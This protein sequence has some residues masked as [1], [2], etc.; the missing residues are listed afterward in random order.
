MKNAIKHA[1]DIAAAFLLAAAIGWTI[2]FGAENPAATQLSAESSPASSTISAGQKFILR[3]ETA[4]HTHYTKKGDAIKFQTAGDIYSGERIVI[5][6]KSTVK[7]IVARSKRAGRLAGRAEV[8]L[9]LEQ[10]E[11]AD[12]STFPLPATITRAG[13]DPVEAKNGQPRIK[14][15]SGSGGSAGTVA[16]SGAQGAIIGVLFGGP[17]GAAYG[18]AIGAGISLGGMLLKRGPDVDLPQDTLFEAKFDKPFSLPEDTVKRM[19]EIAAREA[20]KEAESAKREN[21]RASLEEEKYRNPR[22]RP[23]LR[24]NERSGDPE[25]TPPPPPATE[26]AQP[27]ASP[28]EKAEPAATSDSTT[29]T[30]GT[31]R[32]SASPAQRPVKAKTTGSTGSS[33][34]APVPTPTSNGNAAGKETA[35]T[36]TDAF[37]IKV[38]V[39]MVMVDT[40]VRNKAGRMI[41]NLKLEDFRVFEDGQ[42]QTLGSY[43]RDEMPLA[44]ALVVDRSGSVTPYIY[45]LRRIA[46]RMLDQL[47][48]QDQVCLFSFADQVDRVVD[49][50]SDHDRIVNGLGRI[51]SGGG[52]NIVDAVY[53]AVNYL[54]QAAPDHRRA[55]ILISDNEATVASSAGEGETIRKALNTETVVYSIKTKGEKAPLSVNIPDLLGGSGPVPKM[56]RDTGGEILDASRVS[57]L[58][59]A[60]RTVLTRLRLRYSIGYYSSSTEKGAAFHTI[61]VRLVDRFGKPGSDYIIHARRGYYSI[62]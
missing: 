42:E 7:G 52:T 18:G 1:T 40:V 41:E 43:S 12:G 61:E 21:D 53:G 9:K 44:V 56:T 11:L 22:T 13:L 23:V 33:T 55:V 29:S 16:K 8:E 32:P 20:A 51:H 25:D 58:D 2:L 60:M 14:G 24:R 26:T 62:G 15:D 49:L 45:E 34:P 30:V 35:S 10:L 17:K 57:M 47:K 50:T 31:E 54:A 5:P 4:I 27:Q 6:Q 48:T 3:L 39:R 59:S 28:T 19:E 37:K 46:E 36:E 38:N